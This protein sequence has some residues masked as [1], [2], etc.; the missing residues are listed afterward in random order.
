MNR[1]CQMTQAIQHKILIIADYQNT[2]ILA[3][4]GLSGNL[5]YSPQK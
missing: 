1:L 3:V 4:T 5:S 2:V